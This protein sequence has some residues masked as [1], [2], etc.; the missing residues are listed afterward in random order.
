LSQD[1]TVNGGSRFAATRQRFHDV[2]KHG[3]RL[4]ARQVS[5]YIGGIKTKR[6]C[7]LIKI[8]TSSV[9]VKGND[10]GPDV[11]KVCKHRFRIP[12]RVKVFAFD[13]SPGDMSV[14]TVYRLSCRPYD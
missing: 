7:R 9:M 13:I 8:V 3:A 12:W 11:R 5:F 2:P 14:L 4:A 10:A 1:I 6:A